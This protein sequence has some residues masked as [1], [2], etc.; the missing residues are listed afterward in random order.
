MA[1]EPNPDSTNERRLS[2]AKSISETDKKNKLSLAY[3]TNFDDDTSKSADQYLFSEGVKREIKQNEVTTFYKKNRMPD[4][5]LVGC[6][7]PY[8]IPFQEG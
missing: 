8:F 7:L 5:K 6:M 4:T 3:S 2:G 1:T